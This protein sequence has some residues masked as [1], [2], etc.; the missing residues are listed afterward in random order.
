M[1][2]QLDYYRKLPMHNGPAV[3]SLHRVH[4]Q[5]FVK[6]TGLPQLLA[7]PAYLTLTDSIIQALLVLTPTQRL[8][9]QETLRHP[10][11]FKCQ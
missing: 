6:V 3:F 10:Y 8:T 5:S 2:D 4:Y 7:L 1:I 9:V 11:I